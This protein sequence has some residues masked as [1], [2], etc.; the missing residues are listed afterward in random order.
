[1]LT[2]MRTKFRSVMLNEETIKAFL[3]KKNRDKG[4]NFK[5]DHDPIA[6]HVGMIIKCNLY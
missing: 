2:M 1:M 4:A 6:A 3:I 5:M